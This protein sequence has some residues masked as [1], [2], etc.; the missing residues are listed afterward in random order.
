MKKLLSILG[1][2]GLTATSTTSL[3][4]CDN[5]KSAEKPP[6]NSNWKLV[7][8]I[9]GEGNTKKW[10]I[11]IFKKN[12]KLNIIKW[13]GNKEFYSY[14]YDKIYYWNGNNESTDLQI[15]SINSSTG[16]ITDWKG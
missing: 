6:E 10:C 9:L 2:I 14:Y 15:P 8:N 7:S 3:V 16:E 1:T 12:N 11:G 13:N 4:A 5:N